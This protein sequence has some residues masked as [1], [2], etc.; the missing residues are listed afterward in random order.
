MF[1]LLRRLINSARNRTVSFVARHAPAEIAVHVQYLEYQGRFGRF[2]KPRT[3][4]EHIQHRKLFVDDPRFPLLTDKIEMK[5]AVESM[6]GTGW[7]IPSLWEGEAL[8][9]HIDWSLPFV[10]KA[11]HGCKWNYFAFE[12]ADADRAKLEA[13]AARW[14]GHYGKIFRERHYSLIKPRLL[15]EPFM[16]KGREPPRDYKFFAFGGEIAFIQ[17]DI[18]RFSGHRRRTYTIDWKRTPF[19]WGESYPDFEYDLPPPSSF[20][21]MIWAAGRLS[22]KFEFVRVDFYEIDGDPKIGELTFFPGSG[23]DNFFPREYDLKFGK[24]WSETK[25]RLAQ[26][27]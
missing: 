8:P 27:P 10:L 11:S 14:R 6:L 16:G 3:F 23:W 17:F 18:N 22:E 7:T 25:R 12:E 9:Q 4:T 24:V 21:R 15:V 20:E 19:G 5:R 26:N 1:S 13:A 2:R